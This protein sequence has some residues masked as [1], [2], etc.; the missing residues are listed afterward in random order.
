MTIAILGLGEA[1]S[2]FA[3][4]LAQ[5][6][7]L[8]TGFDPD[9]KRSID[10]KV[11]LAPSNLAAAQKA[12][13]ILSVNLSAVSEEVALEVLPA[14]NSGKIY[15]E[16]NTASPQKKQ[17]IYEILKHKG[18]QYVDLAIMA[19]V[20]P[21]GVYSPFWVSGNGAKAFHEKM[22]PLGLDITLLSETVGEAS[23][24]KLLRSIVYKGVA[25][26]ICEA[27]E[28]GK[29]FGLEDYIRD[30]IGSI[31]GRNDELIDRFIEGSFTHAER[32]MHEMDA[33]V[34]MLKRKDIQ[35][36]M[37]QAASDNL[38]KLIKK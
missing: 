20:P 15:V 24:L 5:K 16:M 18:V 34:E 26:V 7:V 19:P 1:G 29:A 33:V 6:D 3:N 12:D 31:I 36:F 32:R 27:V 35:P 9:L 4:D 17:A 23:T 30:Q 14:L 13:I 22:T 8:V 38:N 28:A 21:K 37:S 2:H 25:A 10:P 11:A